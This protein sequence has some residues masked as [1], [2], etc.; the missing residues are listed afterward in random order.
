MN[1]VVHPL[2]IRE[3]HKH[4]VDI[5]FQSEKC[6]TNGNVVRYQ[7]A[8]CE[9]IFVCVACHTGSVRRMLMSWEQLWHNAVDNNGTLNTVVDEQ[10]ICMPRCVHR[11]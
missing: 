1:C 8:C 11:G 6:T 9:Y 10:L 3:H 4:A 7:S 5:F 2:A